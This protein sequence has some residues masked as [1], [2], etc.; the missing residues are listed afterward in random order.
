MVRDEGT[1]RCAAGNGLQDRRFHFQASGRVEVAAHRGDDLRPLDEGFL[2][3]RVHD[4]VH[5]ALA[6][7]E[8]WIGKAVMD[9]AVGVG[10]DDGKDAEGLGKDREFLRVDGQL[11][12]LGDEGE[13]L[14]TH[15][16]TDVQQLLEHGV[17]QGLV[18]AG[19]DFIPLDIDLDAARVVLQLHKGGCT[20]DTAGHD[21]AG[22][23]HV[24][25]IP[26]FGV[27][28]R[29]DLRGGRIDRIEGSGVGIDPEFTD[30]LQGLPA[31]ALLL[32]E[33]DSRCH[34]K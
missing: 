18:L 4:E 31:S 21:A 24:G 15:D 11:A 12:G 17:V 1:G 2:H 29:R 10:L 7:A 33:F 27:E 8:L 13:T 26:L 5:I 6:V 14:D 22:D 20:H 9:G 25:E 19:A 34:M 28:T 16:V 30:F 32:V 23:A 3:L